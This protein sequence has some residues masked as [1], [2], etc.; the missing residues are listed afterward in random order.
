MVSIHK[1][2]QEKES[3]VECQYKDVKIGVEF[4]IPADIDVKYH[5]FHG[6]FL[7]DARWHCFKDKPW[8]GVNASDAAD[9]VPHPIDQSLTVGVILLEIKGKGLTQKQAKSQSSSSITSDHKPPSTGGAGAE[10]LSAHDSQSNIS[11]SPRRLAANSSS[12]A[13]RQVSWLN[14]GAS[15][16][17]TM[18]SQSG[19]SLNGL[20]GPSPSQTRPRAY[21]DWQSTGSQP[22]RRLPAAAS[23]QRFSPQLPPGL[24]SVSDLLRL[25]GVVAPETLLSPSVSPNNIQPQGSPVSQQTN[26][27][28]SLK[29]QAETPSLMLHESLSKMTLRPAPFDKQLFSHIWNSSSASPHG[30]TFDDL[31]SGCLR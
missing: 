14:H 18:V 29:T 20:A 16:T 2:H 10:G 25:S 6:S 15:F 5:V 13:S 3:P 8:A 31:V 27:T 23:Q 28:G 7:S 17:G 24:P 26:V 4:T 30:E 12:S 22:S 11:G 9:P 19:I 21:S 1:P